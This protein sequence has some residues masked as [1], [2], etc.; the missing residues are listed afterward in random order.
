MEHYEKIGTKFRLLSIEQGK[1]R[2]MISNGMGSSK[3]VP[4]VQNIIGACECV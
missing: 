2:L 4:K 1:D 3:K